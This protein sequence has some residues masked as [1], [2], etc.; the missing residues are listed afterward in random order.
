MLRNLLW[1][2]VVALACPACTQQEPIDYYTAYPPLSLHTEGEWHKAVWG[3]RQDYVRYTVYYQGQPLALP[4]VGPTPHPRFSWRQPLPGGLLLLGLRPAAD[5]VQNTYVLR[6]F[7]LDAPGGQPR[8]QALGSSAVENSQLNPLSPQVWLT[9]DSLGLL[10]GAA[11]GGPTPPK[12]PY[13]FVDLREAG[14]FTPLP[15]GPTGP[16]GLPL[17]L[18]RVAWSADYQLLAL[19]YQPDPAGG[20]AVRQVFDRR[21]GHRQPAGRFPEATD[22]TP[23]AGHPLPAR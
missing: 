15:A 4:Q 16:D 22:T 6:L 19:S 18:R 20:P 14:T 13:R 5:S 10:I 17:E 3:A 9:A 1:L 8:L 2:L 12:L 7:L 23:P 21:T 11:E